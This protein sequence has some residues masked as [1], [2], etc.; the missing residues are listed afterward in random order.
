[1]SRSVLLVCALLGS[2][3]AASAQAPPAPL[4]ASLSGSAAVPPVPVP[5]A[6]AAAAAPAA[7]PPQETLQSFD[8]GRAELDWSQGRWKVVAGDV[9]LKDFGPRQEEARAA[10]RLVRELRLSQRGT[11]GTPGPV[12]EYWLA[13]GR[14]P[15]GLVPALHPVSLDADSLRVEQVQGQWCV[16]DNARVLFTFGTH[17]DEAREALAVIRRHGFT[18]VGSLGRGTP[19]MLVFLGGTAQLSSPARLTPPTFPSRVVPPAHEAAP[20]I[21]QA[22]FSPNGGDGG[23]VTRPGCGS[24]PGRPGRRPTRGRGRRSAPPPCPSAGSRPGRTPRPARTRRPTGCRSTGST[25]R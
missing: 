10:L 7:P 6:P 23:A 8:P 5:A 17:A 19:D 25:S 13:D 12:M 3:A 16:R 22:G 24:P 15:Q 9:V 4:P 14:A 18:Q 20:A 2:A 1:M 21:R 11:V